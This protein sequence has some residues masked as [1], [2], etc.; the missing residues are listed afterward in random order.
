MKD[1]KNTHYLQID[2]KVKNIFR[3]GGVEILPSFKAW[4]KFSWTR[5][6]F[7]KKPKEGYFIWVKKQINFPILT[8]V[9]ISKKSVSQKLQNLLV[10][11]RGLNIELLGNCGVLKKDLGGNHKAGGKIVLKKGSSL[12]YSHIHSWGKKDIVETDYNFIVEDKSK[13]DYSYKS[14]STPKKLKIKTKIDIF[15]EAAANMKITVDCD[16]TET[17]IKDFLTLKEKGASGQIQLRLVGRKNSKI[18][19]YSRI[20]A[21]AEGKG[22]LDCQGLL[23]EENSRVS[24]IPQLVCQ[25]K[26]A[27]I[28]H[29]ASIGKISEDELNYLR[30]RGLSEKQAIDLIINGF[31][32]I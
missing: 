26:N 12:K 9:S 11:E 21:A 30:M 13:L 2:N 1:A 32:G 14:F 17:E 25:N 19:S 10:V 3:S 29:E 5:K 4:E 28:T 24:L 27:Q 18:L 6:Y 7:L 16:Q 15:Q 31:L 20:L 23:V 22:H 8:C